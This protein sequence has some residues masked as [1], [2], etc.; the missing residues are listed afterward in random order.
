MACWPESLPGESIRRFGSGEPSGHLDAELLPFGEAFGQLLQ[1]KAVE[2]PRK[3][4]CLRG[5]QAHAC[6]NCQVMFVGNWRCPGEAP[7]LSGYVFA[8]L[9]F[10]PDGMVRLGL[11]L[12]PGSQHQPAQL[13]QKYHLASKDLNDR[14]TQSKDL[15]ANAEVR[16]EQR[17][18]VAVAF[19][20]FLQSHSM[21]FHVHGLPTY[22]SSF[23]NLLGKW[24]IFTSC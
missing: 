5:K 3:R 13:K 22:W 11:G 17:L 16:K 8:F 21:W 2:T 18:L 10:S 24:A 6:L 7:H 12:L 19:T 20:P 14:H 23:P 4:N 1:P 15:E 9:I